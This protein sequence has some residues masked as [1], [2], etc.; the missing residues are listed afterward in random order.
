MPEPDVIKS[1]R[2]LF[3]G[4]KDKKGESI[5]ASI[6]THI[7]NLQNK[8]PPFQMA[9]G[10][11]AGLCTGYLFTRG[12][13]ATATILG[14]SLVFSR[15][16]GHLLPGPHHLP[17]LHFKDKTVLIT[18]ASSG[19][20]ASLA[21]E[22]YKSG[23]KLILT[24]RRVENLK[25]LCESL[26]RRHTSNPYEPEYRHLDI[27]NISDVESLRSLAI[28]GSTIHVLINNS[29]ISM[30]GSVVDTPVSIHKQL[31][32]TNYF[33]HVAVTRALLSAIPDEGCIIAT[34]SVQGKLPV[35]YRSAYTAS[36]H[37]F[38]AFFDTLRCE[39]R[40]QLHI[41]VVSAGYINTGF[42]SRALDTEG[43]PIGEEDEN[44]RRV[45][46]IVFKWVF[47]VI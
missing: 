37:A 11:G 1:V 36:K 40:P 46:Y 3:P 23:A 10:G 42:G 39:S 19:L 20:G 2:S 9:V 45:K 14:V 22:L 35:P 38:Q 25:E 29:G 4:S 28:D 33:G 24:A 30:R 6:S 12:S 16:V 31:M 41:L 17:T 44:Q 8:S 34:S 5:I 13:K 26:K 32:E 7:D 47:L 21:F 43:R 27:T 15:L 18:G